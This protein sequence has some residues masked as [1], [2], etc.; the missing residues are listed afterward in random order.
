MAGRHVVRLPSLNYIM[1]IPVYA[2][3]KEG[4]DVDTARHDVFRC[5]SKVSNGMTGWKISVEK[6]T[7]THNYSV[8]NV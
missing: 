8:I 3:A 5:F 4:G 2:H 6:H 7:H 1:W